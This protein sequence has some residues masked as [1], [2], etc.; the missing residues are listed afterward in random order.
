ML[1]KDIVAL[2][3]ALNMLLCKVIEDF[4]QTDTNVMDL[5]IIPKI[6]NKIKTPK[7]IKHVSREIDHHNN[8]IDGSLVGLPSYVETFFTL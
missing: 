6:M 5:M 2:V 4:I 1:K 8:V 7:T 3:I